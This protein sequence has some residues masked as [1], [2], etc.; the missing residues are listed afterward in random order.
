LNKLLCSLVLARLPAQAESPF[1]GGLQLVLMARVNL[2]R[3]RI[4]QAQPRLPVGCAV[5]GDAADIIGHNVVGR[6]FALKPIPDVLGKLS[7]LEHS[8]TDDLGLSN[9]ALGFI[10]LRLADCCHSYASIG[11]LCGT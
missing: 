11:T 10:F 3:K 9:Q 8:E 2:L 7:L 5:G 4:D 6:E 1:D